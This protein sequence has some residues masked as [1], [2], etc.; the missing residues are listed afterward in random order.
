[1]KYYLTLFLAGVLT[2]G[3]ATD[4]VN[5]WDGVD[6]DEVAV[7]APLVLPELPKPTIVGD[8]VILDA[9]QAAQIR[10]YGIIA[11]ANTEMA[12][13]YSMSINER[14]RANTALIEAGKA[15]RM[16]SELRR[17]MLEDERRS[18]FFTNIGLYVVIIAL[19][20]AL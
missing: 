9:S 11:R 1:M 5:P 18:N 2:S 12:S 16:Q 15:Q 3:C 6:I 13:E 20:L 4:P 17:G 14:Q 19:G 10:D 7:E 8:Q